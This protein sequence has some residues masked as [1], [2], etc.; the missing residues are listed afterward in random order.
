MVK[1]I[2][3]LSKTTTMSLISD[4]GELPKIIS[5]LLTDGCLT[6]GTRTWRLV[7]AGKSQELHNIFRQTVKDVFGFEAFRE[8]KDSKGITITIFSSVKAGN[9]LIK[10]CNSFR[11]KACKTSKICSIFNGKQGAC[12]KCEPVKINGIDYPK[13]EFDRVFGNL[14]KD[15]LIESFKLAFSSDGGVV[16]GAKWHKRFNRWEFTRRVILKCSHPALR[17]SYV[18]TLAKLDIKAKEWDSSVVIDTKQDIINFA[19]EIGFIDG[20][21]VSQKSLYWEG[22]E[23]NHVLKILLKTF[24]INPSFWKEFHDKKDL[25][26]FLHRIFWRKGGGVHPSKSCTPFK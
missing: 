10:L 20:V 24:E 19:N 3:P 18:N 14:P 1:L 21:E 8:E 5:L 23:K 9:E 6:R 16:L 4:K 2:N 17:K 13:I 11:T 26:M 12:Y 7:Y 22:F 25:I 15:V